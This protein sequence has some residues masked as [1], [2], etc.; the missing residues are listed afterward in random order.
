MATRRCV[1]MSNGLAESMATQR[2]VTMPPGDRNRALVPKEPADA[3]P[4]HRP[5]RPVETLRRVRRR[6]RPRPFGRRGR[7]LHA[8]RPE[9]RRQDHHHPHADGRLQPTAG[10]AR[11][12]GLDCAAQRA[13]IQRH[14]G[15]LPDEPIFYDYLTGREIIQF[16]G[17]MRGFAPARSPVA[18]APFSERLGLSPDLDEF[19]VNYSRGMKKKLAA[20]CALL[21]EPC[22]LVMDE[23]TSGLDPFATRTMHGLLRERAAAGGLRLLQ[24]APPGPGRAAVL[25][26]GHPRPRAPGGRRELAEL[27]ARAAAGSSLEEIFFSVTGGAEEGAAP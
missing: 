21:H 19:A 6:Q 1:A 23:P 9:R 24:H 4:G 2:R 25:A 3:G 27:R 20:V 26:G 14:V 8:P 18:P 10:T 13:E 5:S 7:N 22:V 16:V 15:Y 17:E 12:L 11:V